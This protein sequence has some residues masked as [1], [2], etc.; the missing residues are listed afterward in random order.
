MECF[1]INVCDPERL[2]KFGMK[3][4]DDLG[5]FPPCMIGNTLN[6]HAQAAWLA[7]FIVELNEVNSLGEKHVSM[8]KTVFNSL[9]INNIFARFSEKDDLNK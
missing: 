2:L 4:L 7:P 6:Y 3:K 1:E 8:I 9:T 5:K